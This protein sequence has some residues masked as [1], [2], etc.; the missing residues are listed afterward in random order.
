MQPA[1]GP[2]AVGSGLQGKTDEPDLPK[3]L[4]KKILKAK[5]ASL[6][7]EKKLGGSRKPTGEI[8]IS[9]DALLACSESAKVFISYLTATAN[10]NCIRAKRQ[11]I[12]A[13]DV[14]AALNDTDF[15]ELVGP[16]RESLEAFKVESKE[17]NKAKAEQLKKR[18]LEKEEA[19]RAAEDGADGFAE[20]G[21]GFFPSSSA[22][23]LNQGSPAV[24]LLTNSSRPLSASTLGSPGLLLAP[25]VG[26]LGLSPGVFGAID[27]LPH[28]MLDSPDLLPLGRTVHAP[29]SP[30][31]LV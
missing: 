21:E 20:A 18:K 19:N 14:I 15:T 13:D 26:S 9:K 24:P 1:N 30:G 12:S 16:L 27:N 22:G 3:A 29:G 10:D 31:D 8:Q 25:G 2:A 4:V 6:D 5:L 28:H 7:Q 17:K 23:Q 11:T